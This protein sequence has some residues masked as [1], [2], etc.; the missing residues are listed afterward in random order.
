[1]RWRIYSRGWFSPLL[2][3]L[4]DRFTMTLSEGVTLIT[5]LFLVC[6]GVQ[7]LIGWARSREEGLFFLPVGLVLSGAI[8]LVGVVIRLDGGVGWLFVLAAVTGVGV[9][10]VHPEGLRAIYRIDKI[11]TAT[12]SAVFMLGGFAGFLGGAWGSTY[13][14]SRWGLIALAPLA[15]CPVMMV[16]VCRSL[17]MRLAADHSEAARTEAMVKSGAK[18]GLP[19]WQVVLM[20]IPSVVGATVVMNLLPSRLNELGFFAAVWGGE[21]DG[22]GGRRR[23]GVFLLG[24]VGAAA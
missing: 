3:A 20:M 6:N 4:R 11:P 14:V 7:M 10:F 23:V 8:A 12:C 19:F 5:V 16:L 2:P 24:V 18:A 17:R 9:A 22:S 21:C 1:M 15:L 13:V